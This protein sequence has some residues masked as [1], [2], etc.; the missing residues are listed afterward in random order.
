[1]VS[2]CVED[3]PTSEARQGCAEA[4]ERTFSRRARDGAVVRAERPR[5]GWSQEEFSE[6]AGLDRTYVCGLERG[7]RS[8]NVSAI[9]RVAAALDVRLSRLVLA[10]EARM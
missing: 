7:V 2:T 10:A 6:R 4:P 5:L 9:L 3:R 1:M 8:P